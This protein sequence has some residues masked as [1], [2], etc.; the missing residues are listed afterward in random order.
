MVPAT[1]PRY[2]CSMR[3][4]ENAA[5]QTGSLTTSLVQFAS[6]GQFLASAGKDRNICKSGSRF[7]S[8][9]QRT[10]TGLAVLWSVYGECEN[11]A[12]LAGH[13]NAVLQLRWGNSSRQLVTACADKTVG[14]WDVDTATKLRTWKSHSGIVN[15]VDATTSGPS[16]AVSGSDDGTV[17]LWDARQRG[18]VHTHSIS[19]DGAVPT[20]LPITSVA[21]AKPTETDLLF[22]GGV[23]GDV[24]QYDVRAGKERMTLSGHDAIITGLSVAPERNTIASHGADG[25]VRIWDTRPFAGDASTSI[26]GTNGAAAPSEAHPRQRA[27]LGRTAHSAQRLLHRVALSP[28]GSRVAA[29]SADEM[30]YVW[31]TTPDAEARMDGA[32]R[33]ARMQY[34]LPGH[35]GAVID[36]SWSP[37]EP[38]VAS[39]G[40]DGKVYLGEL[41]QA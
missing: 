21:F 20:P 31:H 26:L 28:D 22:F 17:R 9:C 34:A 15:A 2:V 19:V 37:L 40:A 12:V 4:W 23:A 5:V 14:L 29:G 18:S 27:V 24:V 41:K 1:Q 38:I 13:K 10:P 36:V 35:N 11:Y 7:S 32:G 25:T 6:N 8:R 33:D 3:N 39:C 16:M 30:L